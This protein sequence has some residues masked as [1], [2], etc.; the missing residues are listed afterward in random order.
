MKRQRLLRPRA[1]AA[2]SLLLAPGW[3]PEVRRH[4]EQLIR[5]GAGQG[6]PV[7][8]DFDNTI[9]CGD[10]G[11]ATLAMLV[12]NR[13]LQPGLVPPLLAP[14]FVNA[15]GA[16]VSPGGTIDLT[17]YYER[18]LAPT[19]HAAADPTPLA[20]GYVW[21]TA[22]MQGLTL[23]RVVQATRQVWRLSRPMQERR[24]EVTRG[25]TA[26]PIP[27]FYPAVVELIAQLLRH[28]FDVWVVS[29]S[30]VW[31]VRWMV[32]H[33]LA[34]LLRAHGLRKGI[35]ADHVVGVA[36]LLSDRQHR[37][38]KD[39][40]LVKQDAA[41]AGFE[42][43][44]LARFRLTCQL[45]FP[46]PTYSGKVAAI[47]DQLGR[48]PYLAVG[49]SP[50]DHA[51]LAFAEHRLWLARI[52][53]P[54]Y[55]TATRALAERTGGRQWLVQPTRTKRTPGFLDSLPTDAAPEVGEL[56]ALAHL[57]EDA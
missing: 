51:M 25:Q 41:Y 45:Q 20:N 8:F 56:L 28:R 1:P 9:V 11:E 54:E 21:A 30:N 27:F 47:W 42:A 48:R 57:T 37:F 2:G 36:T 7:T 5:A 46:V 38:Y 43:P 32:L 35:P 6:L 4:L 19:A 10:I 31:S 44:A 40:V 33:A 24:L 52:D 53:K 18:L 49:D 29:A 3:R 55:Q 12:R 23:R 22:V 16:R 15:A 17:D 39:A 13:S 26:Y 34:P 14:S 50:G